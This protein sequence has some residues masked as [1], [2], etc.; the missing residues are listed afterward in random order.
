MAQKTLLELDTAAPTRPLIKIDGIE[1]QL[2]V[3]DDL[4]LREEAELQRMRK[5]FA[6]IE[7]GENS[8]ELANNL[9]RMVKILL[10]DLPDEVLD[11]LSDSKKLRIV[12]AFI[13]EVGKT[14]Q[15]ASPPKEAVLECEPS[16]GI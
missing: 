16:S 7:S 1:Y 11:R 15:P 2:K 5:S 8:A 13:Q 12:S 14:R 10:I 6:E 3:Q 9:R 4:G